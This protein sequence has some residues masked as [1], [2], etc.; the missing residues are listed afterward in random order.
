[1]QKSRTWMIVLTYVSLSAMAAQQ[2][3]TPKVQP[4]M[5][6]SSKAT[7][8]TPGSGAQGKAQKNSIGKS[9]LVMFAQEPVSFW[10]EQLSFNGG[11]VTTDFLYNP[12]IGVLYGYREDDF[13]CS[14]GQT[15]HGGILEALYTSGNKAGKPAGSGWWAVE[16]SSSKCGDM[17]SSV[18]GCKFDANGNATECG[19]ATVHNVTGEMNVAATQ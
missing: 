6:P 10:Q 9:A 8:P 18:Y 11:V 16:L 2:P 19:A 17:N 5:I 1:M 3:I 4:G 14:N 15:A 12:D 13:S 7:N